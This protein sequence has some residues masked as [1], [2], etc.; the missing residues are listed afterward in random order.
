MNKRRYIFLL[1]CLVLALTAGCSPADA[2][3]N[4]PEQKTAPVPAGSAAPAETSPAAELQTF[5]LSKMDVS[6]A[7]AEIITIDGE[8]AVCIYMDLANTADTIIQPSNEAELSVEQGGTML[9]YA[10]TESQEQLELS[11]NFHRNIFPG[12]T[13]RTV[14]YFALE[15]D[16]GQL[17]LTISDMNED[18][19]EQAMLD[20]A[21]LPPVVQAQAGPL[22]EWDIEAIPGYAGTEAAFED[23]LRTSGQME[24]ADYEFVT[25]GQDKYVVLYFDLLVTGNLAED[26]V[27][28]PVMLTYFLGFQEGV[29]LG[30]ST[31]FDDQLAMESR[32]EIAELATQRADIGPNQPV[33]FATA[34]RLLSDADIY[35]VAGFNSSDISLGDPF[36]GDII[37]VE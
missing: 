29:Q 19:S 24:L 26:E 32:E 12:I 11:D 33:R 25:E 20:L 5:R 37:A 6:L 9:D 35:V 31:V 16:G 4:S 21:A 15:Q 7:G 10:M 34:Y 22:P 8:Q 18:I 17:T 30:S 13:L 28:S 14:Q 36:I 1:L 3:E 2:P 27:E 23:A